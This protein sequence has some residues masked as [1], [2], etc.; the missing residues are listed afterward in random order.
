MHSMLLQLA[1]VHL[2]HGEWDKVVQYCNDAALLNPLDEGQFLTLAAAHRCACQ[3]LHA[4]RERERE[5]E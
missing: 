4:E 1:E 3:A 5:R 2:R